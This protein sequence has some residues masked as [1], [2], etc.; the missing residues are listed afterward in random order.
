MPDP[1]PGNVPSEAFQAQTVSEFGDR[2]VFEAATARLLNIVDVLMS[3][4][5]CESGAWHLSDC[6]TSS[7]ATFSHPITLNI[8]NVAPS[9]A[10]GSLLGTR[11]QTFAIPYRPSADDTN[12]TGGNDGKWFN[13]T[14]CFNGFA[15]PITFDLTSLNLTVP[16]EVIISVAYNTSSYGASPIGTGAACF[17]EDGG[18][19]YDALNVALSPV[20]ANVNYGSNPS[21]TDAYLHAQIGGGTGYCTNSDLDVFRLDGSCWGG[22][23]PALTV[24]ASSAAC[25]T[26]CYVDA[27]SG[28]DGNSGSSPAEA[29]KTIQAA[30]DQVSAGG[31]VIVA[32]GTYAGP[33][34]VTKTVELLGAN[35]GTDPRPTCTPSSPSI[36]DGGG[37]ALHAD[38]IVLDGFTVQGVDSGPYGV[39][40]HTSAAVA[41]YEIRNNVIRDNTFG[42][43]LNSDGD[44]PTIVERNCFDSNNRAGSASGEAIYSD[45]GL[46]DAM[47]AD[48]KSTGHASAFLVLAGTQSNITI[49]NNDLSGDSSIVSFSTTDLAITGNTRQAGV[50]S[51]IYLGGGNTIVQISGNTI[52]GASTGVAIQDLIGGSPNSDVTVQLNVITGSVGRGVSIAAGGLTEP[53]AVIRNDLSNSGTDALRN[54]SAFTLNGQCNWWGAAD[55]P[56]GAGPGSG[57]P[58]TSNV[59]YTP[60]LESSVLTA[61][62][63]G[64]PVC[65]TPPFIDVPIDHPFC[66]EI[67]W[68]KSEGISTGFGDGTYRPLTDVTRQAMAAFMARLADATLEPCLTPP[69]PDVPTTN[70]FC[71]E[72]QWMK[73]QGITTGFEDGTYRPLDPVLRQAMAAF[74]LRVSA[75][76]P[77]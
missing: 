50:G 10:V 22:L 49:Q 64:A 3:S 51:G 29:K 31:T 27:I 54:A 12:C 2:I 61:P 36:I 58:V 43:Y 42:L 4:W 44:L 73:E 53:A 68:M 60:W 33:I 45:G 40:V 6:L 5:G 37:I 28:N 63:S 41:G 71:S 75:L 70:P 1:V 32:A 19:G 9:N 11:T 55:G 21:T 18:C 48:N 20:P 24:Y 69:F 59:D 35:A 76:L 57:E 47:V 52:N 7:D 77:L 46:S 16:D 25:S 72:I 8:Y 14:A 15:T 67:Q 38:S 66:A 39:G 34:A 13:G 62:C 56:S 17:S 26:T 30:V 65:L 23:K 74:M